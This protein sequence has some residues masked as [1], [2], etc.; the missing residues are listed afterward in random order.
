[1]G[2][3]LEDALQELVTL[4][5]GLLRLPRLRDVLLDADE[6]GQP[7]RGVENRGDRQLVPERGAVL[8]VVLQGHPTLAPLVQGRADLG[9][10]RPVGFGALEEPAVPTL[11]LVARVPG[12]RRECR[13]V[14]DDRLVGQSGVADG[15]PHPGRRDGPLGHP[16]RLL[17]PL[18]LHVLADLVPDRRD[19]LQQFLVRGVFGPGEEFE[20]AEDLAAR[21][22]REGEGRAAGPRRPRRRDAGPARRPRRP[23]PRSALPRPRPVPADPSPCRKTDLLS[24]LCETV[25]VDPGCL[26]DGATFKDVPTRVHLPRGADVPLQA[27]ADRLEESRKGDVESLGFGQDPADGV[28]HRRPAL[29]ASTLGDVREGH[30]RPGHSPPGEDRLGRVLDR[31]S[32]TRPVARTPRRRH[33]RD[34]PP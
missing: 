16:Q 17:G 29:G 9:D 34:G 3:R 20:H 24:R 27:L 22:D 4:P 30:D 23:R 7:A 8:A 11:D 13:V 10:D 26:P 15:D 25:I 12:D 33:E 14:V 2:E 32:G 21:P 5:D 19:G 31:A 1:M 18:A 28:L 6:M